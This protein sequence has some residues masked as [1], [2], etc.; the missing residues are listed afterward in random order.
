MNHED[1]DVI[2]IKIL[3]RTYKIE[4]TPSEAHDLQNSARYLDEQMRQ[5]RQ[6]GNI[7]STDRVAIVTA[8]NISHEL[9]QL[10]NQKDNYINMMNHQIQ[11]I[12]KRIQNLLAEKEEIAV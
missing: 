3:D 12:Q 11:D 10:K 2:S 8:L 7:T 6:S 5:I 4:C 1:N 9:M